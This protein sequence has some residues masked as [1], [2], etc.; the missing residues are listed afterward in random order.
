MAAAAHRHVWLIVEDDENDF[1]LFSR[2]CAAAV[3]PS[4]II[5]WAKDGKAAVDVL[6][7]SP[8]LPDLVISDIKMPVMNG[9]ELLAWVRGTDAFKDLP[10]V[11]LTSSGAE[12]DIRESRELGAND[13]RI[14]PSGLRDLGKLLQEIAEHAPG[15]IRRSAVPFNA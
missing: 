8:A 9:F 13:Y 1:V 10:F 14:K 15:E 5:C 3:Q 7:S 12:Q 11:M 4:P 6:N 2:A